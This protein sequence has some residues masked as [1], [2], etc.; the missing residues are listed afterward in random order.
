MFSP[1][2]RT[3]YL[4]TA[5]LLSLASSMPHLAAFVHTSTFYAN[6]HL[7]AAA[8]NPLVAE[9]LY[10]LDLGGVGPQELVAQLMALSKDEAGALAAQHMQR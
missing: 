4:G 8:R 6:N 9:Q 5:A 3:N 1:L 10:P 7:G 2:H